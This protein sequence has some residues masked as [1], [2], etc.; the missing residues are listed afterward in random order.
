MKNKELK[1]LAFK[2]ADEA[3]HG[4]NESREELISLVNQHALLSSIVSDEKTKQKINKS[5]LKNSVMTNLLGIT[6]SRPWDKVK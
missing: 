4:N 5:G 2:L 6:S 1:K 3:Y